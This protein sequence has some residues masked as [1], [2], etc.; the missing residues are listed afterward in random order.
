[1]NDETLTTV[2]IAGPDAYERGRLAETLAVDFGRRGFCVLVN[3]TE[4]R[5]PQR[6]SSAP[7]MVV[8]T[9]QP[10]EDTPTPY[11]DDL[12]IE[13]RPLYQSAAVTMSAANLLNHIRDNIHERNVV[14]GWWN[15][16]A[17]GDDLHGKRN[18]G[19]LLCLVHSEISEAM[20]GHRKGLQDDKLPHR[21]MIEVELADAMIR[22]FD[23]AGGYG[24][25]LGGALVE[26]LA[27]NAQRADHKPENRRAAGGKAF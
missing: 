25:D 12:A 2:T 20:E 14:A 16:L 15:D 7:L 13:A 18:V 10:I 26:K 24:L 6:K 27:Y 17:T 5:E 3:P 23:L 22:I 21:P 9:Q 11:F 1:V 8:R 4:G 19:E